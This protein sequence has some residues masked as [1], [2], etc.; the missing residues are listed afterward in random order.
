MSL[1][2]EDGDKLSDY[3]AGK[4]SFVVLIHIL[5]YCKQTDH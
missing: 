3:F 1:C 5:A 4:F 2:S